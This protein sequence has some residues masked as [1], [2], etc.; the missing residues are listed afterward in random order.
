M[1]YRPTTPLTGNGPLEFHIDGCDDFT[2][3]SET[4]LYVKVQIVNS[5]G[6]PLGENDVVAPSNLSYIHYLAKLR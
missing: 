6:K 2:N 1:E 3:L 5:D 4:Y